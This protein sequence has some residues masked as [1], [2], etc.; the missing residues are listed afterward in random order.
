M[1]A[2][3]AIRAVV[4]EALRNHSKIVFNG[5][6]YSQ[7]WKDLAKERGL[8]NLVSTADVLEAV[9]TEE[10]AV[11][12]EKYKIFNRKE[13]DSFISTDLENYIMTIQLESDALLSLTNR[14]LLPA[15]IEYQNN[16]LKN[17]DSV[18]TELRK[19]IKNLID[20]SYTAATALK[21]KQQL[22]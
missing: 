2:E 19:D 10:N 12:F 6:G 17:S 16:L 1:S 13:F 4:A 11:L 15:A 7:E 14:Y 22:K 9:K 8:Q 18:P 21:K 20:L 5:N 3:A